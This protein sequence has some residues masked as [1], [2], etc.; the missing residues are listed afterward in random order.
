VFDEMGNCEYWVRK[1]MEG[2]RCGFASIYLDTQKISGRI[3]W[4]GFKLD[5][6][7]EVIHCDGSATKLQCEDIHHLGHIAL[8]WLLHR[9]TLQ[10]LY[11]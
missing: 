10:L 6:Q 8:I 7:E 5:Q 1:D 2:G 11:P 9:F 3:A 4:L